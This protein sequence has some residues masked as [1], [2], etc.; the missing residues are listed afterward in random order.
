MDGLEE[1][2]K[3][4]AAEK[5]ARESSNSHGK[6]REQH[7][8]RHHR[9]RHHRSRDED[10]ERGHRHKRSRHSKESEEKGHSESKLLLP[11]EAVAKAK[12]DSWMVSAPEIEYTQRL[13]KVEKP[14]KPLKPDYDLKIHK[15]ELNRHLQ[16][17]AEGKS[18]DDLPGQSEVDYTFGDA[19]SQWRLTKLKA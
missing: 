10:G 15:N 3:A 14:T 5:I 7:H 19:G 13:T 4:L 1:F 17:L 18:L 16:D 6:D 12:R 11:D 2:E 9:S 8:R